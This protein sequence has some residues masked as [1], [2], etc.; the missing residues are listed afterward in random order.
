ML[1]P[2][3]IGDF[4]RLTNNCIGEGT[5]CQRGLCTCPFATHPNEDFTECVPDRKLFEECS[6]DI[7]CIVEASRCDDDRVCRCAA[8]YVISESHSSCLKGNREETMR[9]DVQQLTR[10]HNNHCNRIKMSQLLMRTSLKLQSLIDYMETAKRM[11][12]ART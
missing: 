9:E 6:S 2:S 1:S 10:L 8:D 12:N 11:D 4:C 7:E 3:G 5:L